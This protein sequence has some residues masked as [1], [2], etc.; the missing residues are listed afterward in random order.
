MNI[1]EKLS[2]LTPE[3]KSNICSSRDCV[4]FPGVPRLGIPSIKGSDGP[5]GLRLEDGRTTTAFPC[6][7][8]LA[9]SFDTSLAEEY[10]RYLGEETA[11][12]G[13]QIIFGPGINLMRT[14]MNGRNFEYMGE[15]PCLAGNIAAGYVRGCQSVGVAASP[16]H[17]ALNNQEICRTNGSSE[18]DPE[19]IRNLY[20]EA[21]RI[22]VEKAN[23]WTIMSSYNKINGVFASQ[24]GDLQQKL[25]KDE[26]GYDGVVVSD[27]GAVHDGAA[28]FCNGLDAELAG[29]SYPNTVL[30]MVLSGDI[31]ESVLDDH[32]SRMLRLIERTSAGRNI[33]S[34]DEKKHHGFVRRAGAACTVMLK[35][36]DELLPLDPEK[37]RRILVTGPAAEAYHCIGSLEKQGGSGA[38]HPPWEV[39]P[40]EGMN[41]LKDKFQIDY[42]PCFRSSHDQTLDPD[43]LEKMTIRYFDYETGELFFEEELK[44]STLHWGYINAG[45]AANDH[46]AL[47]RK[48]RG[49]ITGRIKA[50]KKMQGKF[51]FAD[52]RLKTRLCYRDHVIDKNS[53][54]IPLTV[55]EADTD[56]EFTVAFEHVS[57]RYVELTLLWHEENSEKIEQVLSMAPQY[58]AVI[59]FGGR[60]HSQDKEAIGAGDVPGA[61]IGSWELPD[62]QD[63]FLKSLCAVNSNV[64][65]IFNTGGPFDLR[66]WYEKMAA[67]LIC[68]YPGMEFGNSVVDLLT[69]AAE[70]EGR[71]PFTWGAALEDYA[72]HANGAYP[73][74]RSGEFPHTCYTEGE[75]IGYRYFD[76]T[77]K[78]ILYP[79]GFG[80]GYTSFTLENANVSGDK[81]LQITVT[82]KNKGRRRGS[83]VIHLYAGGRNGAP[84]KPLK[85]LVDFQKVSA[86]PGEVA[87][88]DFLIDEVQ[89]EKLKNAGFTEFLT[90]T[91]ALSLPGRIKI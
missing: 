89:L 85:E 76:R 40:L 34:Y 75:L 7:M 3:E 62:G 74:V 26:W 73:G 24:C 63:G 82:L 48:F 59:Y 12:N 9:A 35:N 44:R 68:W 1:V 46:P 20:M 47:K 91:N 15:D 30:S 22:V 18:C 45:G 31:P 50:V 19:V 11:A 23:P 33:D 56:M 67:I 49:E 53:R 4:S 86:D 10:G 38:V 29:S 71:L 41:N 90:G 81:D 83:E 58:D 80:M 87:K 8:A 69:G 55:I 36:E 14:P 54:N 28:C 61:D 77:G 21:F 65:G 6:C 37:I 84:D 32:A 13:F 42:H 51:T 57:D 52:S 27:A 39:T 5:Q 64:I 78:G 70:P 66:S 72:C 17:M 88:V 16:K 2:E 79:F 60:T 25:L 43:L